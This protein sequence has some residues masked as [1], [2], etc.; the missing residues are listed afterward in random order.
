MSEKKDEN[1]VADNMLD[2]LL[3]LAGIALF[4][5]CFTVMTLWNEN[6]AELYE[7]NPNM[8]AGV[9]LF[10]GLFFFVPFVTFSFYLA[11]KG[12]TGLMLTAWEIRK[13]EEEAT[14]R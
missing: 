9:P 11:V 4:S 14:M 3:L 7:N 8:V 13:E 5:I 6:R 10:I 1:Q 12:M 2:G